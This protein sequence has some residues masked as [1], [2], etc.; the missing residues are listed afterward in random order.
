MLFQEPLGEPYESMTFDQLDERI[1]AH[2]SRLGDRLVILGHHY[3]QDDVIRYADFTGDSLKLA[4][5]AAEQEKAEFIVFCGVHF[6]AESADMLTGD[7]QVVILPDL[8][9]GCS[10]ADMTDAIDLR[11][12][13]DEVTALAGGARIVPITYV[14][15]TAAVKAVTGRAGGAC[16]TSGNCRTVLEW[17]LRSQAD[18]GAGGAKVLAAPDQ[19]LVRATALDMGYDL[20]DCAV[21]RPTELNGGL[22]AEQVQAATFILWEGFCS[23]HQEFTVEQIAHRRKQY[24]GIRVIVHPECPIDVVQAADLHGSTEQIIR[25]I[26]D[27]A[28]GSRWAVGT[29]I[30]LVNRLA[31]RHTDRLVVNLADHHCLCTTMYR[32]DPAHLC[33]ALD[34]LAE[35]RIVNRITVAP[36]VKADALVALDRM[37]NLKGVTDATRTR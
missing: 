17:A 4:R 18:G 6:M 10:M 13:L 28:P 22:T 36:D 35:G 32:I 25:A 11:T 15:S 14:N 20:D 3:Q 27:A 23:V 24:P 21:Y 33:W 5:L 1:R 31:N 29:E 12:C 26:A 7:D 16:C 8:S 34:N 30:N 37:V 19:H 2:K 9:A